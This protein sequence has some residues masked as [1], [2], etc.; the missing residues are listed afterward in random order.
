MFMDWLTALQAWLQNPALGLWG[1]VLSAFAAATLLPVSSEVVLTA[2]AAA[3]PH[4]MVLLWA[5]ATL[6]NTAGG[7]VTYAIGR[8]AWAVTHPARAA[9]RLEQIARFTRLTRHGAAITALGWL[10]WVGEALVLAAGYLRLS[11]WQCLMWQLLG[12]GARYAVVLGAL[13]V[14]VPS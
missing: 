3:Q 7:M 5:A 13:A 11:A 4:R 10:P 12:R 8:G 1:V 6:A 2:F 9:N 14:V